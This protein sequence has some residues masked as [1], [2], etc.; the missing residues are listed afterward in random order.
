MV[1][2]DVCKL[3][4]GFRDNLKSKRLT[5]FSDRSDIEVHHK[6][7]KSRSLKTHWNSLAHWNC[8]R[9]VFCLYTGKS[10]LFV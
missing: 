3:D 6:K 9:H 10:L 5:N 4:L 2:L 8:S 1:T 7:N